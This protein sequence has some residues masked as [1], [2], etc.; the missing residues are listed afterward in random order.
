MS[1]QHWRAGGREAAVIGLGK[2]GV[3]AGLLLRRNAIPVYASDRAPK[4]D[5]SVGEAGL[6][7]LR[8]AGA[9]VQLGGHDFQ[10]I[11]RAGVCVVSPGVPPDAPPVAAARE[12][13][14]TIISEIDVGYAALP[15]VRFAVIT[16]TNG[17]TTTTALTAHLFSAAGITG[18][19]AGNIGQPLAEVALEGLSP[20]WVALEMSSFQLHDTYDLVP[21]IGALTNLAPD[22]LDRYPTLEAYYADK[23]L[24]YR[25]ASDSSIWVTNADDAEVQRRAARVPGRHLRFSLAHPA[26]AWYDRAARTLMLGAVP[27][28]PRDELHLF[29]DHNV[30]NA[31]C[32]ALIA[33]RAGAGAA[34]I[35]AGLRTFRALAHRMEPVGEKDGVVWINDSKATNVAST[36]VAVQALERPFVL[37]LGGR[38]KGE[39]YTALAEAAGGRCKAVLAFGESRELV[40]QD[41]QG[42]LP[43]E[44]LGTD[45]QEV[46]DRARALAAPG[47]AVLL[48]PACSSYDMFQNYED[49]GARFRAAV[50]AL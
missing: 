43:V 50:A 32:A 4:A 17:K 2:S 19:A 5:K 28:L 12:A 25:N 44:R 46:I 11:A 26:E 6:A 40:T 14:V 10:R 22:H 47:D 1:F 21:T 16:G 29:G 15:S 27:L 45:F 34:G 39:P 7:R 24:L 42:R 9:T 33:S 18:T 36:L 38:H 13:G 49:R 35:A 3:A 30:A 20:S 37:L 41:L 23:D 31:L 48:S 8:E